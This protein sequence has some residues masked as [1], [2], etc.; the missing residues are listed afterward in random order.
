MTFATLVLTVGLVGARADG[1]L[2]IANCQIVDD[3]GPIKAMGV[4]YVDGFWNFAKDGKRE[5]YLP[6]LDALAEA[7]IPFIRMA[8][9]PWAAYKPDAPPAP[10]I[11]DFV[12]DHG[13]Y[14]ERLDT[15]L[16][17]LRARHIGVVLDVFW[18]VDPYAVYFG[19]PATASAHPESRT[20]RF[21]KEV[22]AEVVRRHRDDP[23]IWMIE[24]FNEGNLSIDYP[25]ARRTRTDLIALINR[26][27]ATLHSE[28]DQHLMD[29]GNSLP[30]PAAQHLN[31]HG[32][33]KPD[34]VVEF[35]RALS[36]ETPSDI[37]VVSVHIYPENKSTRPWDNNDILNVLPVVVR[38]NR[39]TCRPVFVGEFGARDR[40]IE[41]TYLR[42]VAAGGIQMA[43]LWGFGRP[44]FDPF[45]IGIDRQGRALLARLGQLSRR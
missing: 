44:K 42:R 43:A 22:L 37:G 26:L 25:R 19:E 29:T 31:E 2:H 8:F 17:D 35:L 23:T 30:R 6:Y 13:R 16:A 4:N 33:W 18:N 38:S 45:E 28:G 40:E 27:A 39:S 9:G 20:F 24:F 14:F 11:A 21:L 15:F 3:H 7:R 34:S 1:L 32:A 5:A 10:Q 41:E 12:V 36:A